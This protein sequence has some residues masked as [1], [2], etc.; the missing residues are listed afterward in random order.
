LQIANSWS[1]DKDGPGRYK[2]RKVL[3]AAALV[4]LAFF[5]GCFW[6]TR[7]VQQRHDHAMLF[8]SNIALPELDTCTWQ[9]GYNAQY[10]PAQ[11]AIDFV[12]ECMH[13]I[14]KT[15]HF[16]RVDEEGEASR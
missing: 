11:K 8:G 5:A 10:E 6:A 13:A 12:S 15:E 1:L 2:M 16:D 14:A 7:D 3:V 4:A 9:A